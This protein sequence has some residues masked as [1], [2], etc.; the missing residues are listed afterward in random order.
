MP[1]LWSDDTALMVFCANLVVCYSALFFSASHFG[2]LTLWMIL[3]RWYL[4]QLEE[5]T[6]VKVGL[7]VLIMALSFQ[8]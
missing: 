5:G 4:S 3:D 1:P 6:C 8:P 7:N 2:I